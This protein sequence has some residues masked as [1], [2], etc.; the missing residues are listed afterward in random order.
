MRATS[1]STV[2]V[3]WAVAAA[4]MAIRRKEVGGQRCPPLQVYRMAPQRQNLNPTLMPSTRGRSGT[5][6]LMNCADE[7]NRL[8]SELPRLV[9]K[10]CTVHWSFAMLKAASYV[11]YA[12]WSYRSHVVVG[13]VTPAPDWKLLGS[14]CMSPTCCAPTMKNIL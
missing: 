2:E 6:D 8:A 9:P 11:V 3:A 14:F 5:S 13:T 4:V 12:G 7:V 10:N 1:D